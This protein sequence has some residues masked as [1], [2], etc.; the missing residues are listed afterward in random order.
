MVLLREK[1]YQDAVK[2]ALE[3]LAI[4]PA[5][6]DAY[7]TLGAAYYSLGLYDKSEECFS[8]A[9]GL[10]GGQAYRSLMNLA[11]VYGVKGRR[12]EALG[13]YRKVVKMAPWS[14]SAYYNMG[15]ILAGLGRRDKV[16]ASNPRSPS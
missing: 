1:Y 10:S 3:S 9:A 5:Y 16:R 6:V 11:T 15:L 14:D 7:N 4:D 12:E 13:I 8:K 2:N